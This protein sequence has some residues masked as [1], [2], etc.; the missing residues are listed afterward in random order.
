MKGRKRTLKKPRSFTI[1]VIKRYGFNTIT[2]Q[3]AWYGGIVLWSPVSQGESVF[4]QGSYHYEKD[5]RYNYKLNVH[6]SEKTHRRRDRLFQHIYWIIVLYSIFILPV[7]RIFSIILLKTAPFLFQKENCWWLGRA[8]TE[9]ETWANSEPSGCPTLRRTAEEG[10]CQGEVASPG[11]SRKGEQ[12][13]HLLLW[14][15][16]YLGHQRHSPSI[17]H[18]PGLLNKLRFFR[19]NFLLK[20]KLMQGNFKKQCVSSRLFTQRTVLRQQCW[21]ERTEYVVLTDF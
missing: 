1:S 11:L 3:G 7:C 5:K 21:P 13:H 6:L 20:F 9:P 10:A 14:K 17:Q 4:H 15:S 2:S 16:V 12:G 18:Q 8:S 19:N